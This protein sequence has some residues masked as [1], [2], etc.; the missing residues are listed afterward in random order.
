MHRDHLAKH[1]TAKAVTARRQS[2]RGTALALAAK[3]ECRA[4]REREE[5]NR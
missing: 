3:E 5:K 2:R 1:T 4:V